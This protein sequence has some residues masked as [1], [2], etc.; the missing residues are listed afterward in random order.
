MDTTGEPLKL[1][2]HFR[3]NLQGVYNSWNSWKSPGILFL[4][5]EKFVTNTVIFVH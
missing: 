1:F 5:L 3:L 4:L 2:S